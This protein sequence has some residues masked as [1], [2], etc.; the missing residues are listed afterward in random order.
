MENEARGMEGQGVLSQNL[1]T[2]NE[3]MVVRNVSQLQVLIHGSEASQNVGLE[4]TG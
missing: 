1:A 3:K 2:S 4:Q